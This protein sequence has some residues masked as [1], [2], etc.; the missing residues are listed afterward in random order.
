MSSKNKQPIVGEDGELLQP[1]SDGVDMEA[2][3]EYA[4]LIGQ[5]VV[6]IW[7]FWRSDQIMRLRQQISREGVFFALLIL[8]GIAGVVYINTNPFRPYIAPP[9]GQGALESIRVPVRKF[10]PP[11]RQNLP[12]SI[13]APAR[14][15]FMTLPQVGQTFDSSPQFSQE[16]ANV[17]WSPDGKRILI[18]MQNLGNLCIWTVNAENYCNLVNA[19]ASNISIDWS[20][21]SE[22]YAY[23]NPRAQKLAVYDITGSRL[24]FEFS[25]VEYREGPPRALVWSSDNSRIATLDQ[26]GYTITVL[27]V[28]KEQVILRESWYQQLYDLTWLPA[29]NRLVGV[30]DDFIWI[31]QD[32]TFKIRSAKAVESYKNVAASPDGQF[33]AITGNRKLDGATFSPMLKV[34]DT[35]EWHTLWEINPAPEATRRRDK[36]MTAVEWSP[37]NTQIATFETGSNIISLWDAN[38]GELLQQ[39][40]TTD[41]QSVNAIDWSPDGRYLAIATDAGLLIWS[42]ER[43]N[44]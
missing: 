43:G 28:V 4:G 34:V 17:S 31:W 20:P 19:L 2:Y 35:E 40:S 38:S 1:L 13:L 32:L 6:P 41:G 27:D 39:F 10:T 3:A 26:T 25:L 5:N 16:V 36:L 7:Q 33:V 21:N 44:G 11:A 37:E 42:P 22:R 8:S 15:F 9:A 18:V 24:N 23:R 14:K 12:E 30:G 29:E